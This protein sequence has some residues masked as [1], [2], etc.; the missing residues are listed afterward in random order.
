LSI[1]SP[2]HSTTTPH[3]LESGR[4]TLSMYNTHPMPRTSP[5]VKRPFLHSRKTRP[6]RRSKRLLEIGLAWDL[7]KEH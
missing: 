5:I 6:F 2:L 7:A 3:L 4:S 1:S